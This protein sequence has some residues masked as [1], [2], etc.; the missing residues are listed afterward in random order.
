MIINSTVEKNEKSNVNNYGSRSD[1]ISGG[2]TCLG[3]SRQQY[4]QKQY[5]F[6]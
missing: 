4:V 6:E 1:F 3:L 5:L 2:S